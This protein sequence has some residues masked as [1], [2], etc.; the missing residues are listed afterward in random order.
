MNW[1][2]SVPTMKSWRR[3]TSVP[4]GVDEVPVMIV[5]A[6]AGGSATAALLAK[7]GVES[8]VVEKRREV[9]LYPKARN[10]SFR[11][12]EILRG[13]GLQDVVHPAAAGVPEA[14]LVT[15]IRLSIDQGMA[16]F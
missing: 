15:G 9:F 7:Y 6:G 5:S 11:S 1:N 2:Y 16:Q 4:K 10:L 13:L 3:T 12:L 8:L 14:R